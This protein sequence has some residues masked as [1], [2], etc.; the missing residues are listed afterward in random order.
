MLPKSITIY[1][2]RSVDKKLTFS[3]L[4][5]KLQLSQFNLFY[6]TPRQY[7]LVP[8]SLAVIGILRWLAHLDCTQRVAVWILDDVRKFNFRNC[9]LGRGRHKKYCILKL[10][11]NLLLQEILPP[12][13]KYGT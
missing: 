3:F 8:L 7:F 9:L 11:F 10:P 6:I 5:N 1:I 4:Q 12:P 2:I 13:S